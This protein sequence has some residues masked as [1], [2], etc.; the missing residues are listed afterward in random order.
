[1]ID[2]VRVVARG[3][4]LT[5]GQSGLVQS[6][7]DG[8]FF[9]LLYSV[10]GG[11]DYF[12]YASEIKEKLRKHIR[13]VDVVVIRVPSSIGAYA[14]SVCKE[15]GKP[16]ITEVVGCAWD[17]MWHY[18]NLA[19]KVLA[20]IKFLKMRKIVRDSTAALYVTKHFLQQKY[21]FPGE[22]TENAS[23]VHIGEVDSSVLETR[24]N[25]INSDSAERK[26][27]IGMLS[28]VGVKYKGFSVA[29][30]ALKKLKESEPGIEFELLLAGGGAADYVNGLID[31]HEM[32]GNV[33]LLGQLSSGREVFDFLDRLDVL[34]QPSLL[35]GLPRSTIEAMS[36]GC[37]VLASSAGGIPELINQEFLHQPGDVEKLSRD[38]RKVLR[39]VDL[40][41]FMARRNYE[42]A[43]DYTD[44]VLSRRRVDFY[45]KAFRAIQ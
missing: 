10:K 26:F 12:R 25:K 40:Q 9:D 16:Y 7:R 17:S 37:P 19:G 43:K 27:K 42:I 8:V 32:H 35:E 18:G 33:K 45:T 20:P 5:G 38:L 44:D 11:F 14:Y 34:L 41:I 30:Q 31:A 21:P 6:S 24:L 36:R 13:E 39:D 15:L 22:I 3:T 23:N 1:L 28:N 29:I 4:V 2:E